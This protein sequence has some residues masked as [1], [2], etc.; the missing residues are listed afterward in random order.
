MWAFL[1]GEQD[2][3]EGLLVSQ[4]GEEEEERQ[5]GQKGGG[6]VPR[7]RIDPYLLRQL[8]ATRR[9]VV[10]LVVRR[11]LMQSLP[12]ECDCSDEDDAR[13]EEGE[14]R[15]RARKKNSPQVM[16]SLLERKKKNISKIF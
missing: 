15:D 1:R 13:G 16:L 2:G 11:C 4:E 14:A 10:N 12:L 5:P 9:D 7:R 6:G 8:W 3:T